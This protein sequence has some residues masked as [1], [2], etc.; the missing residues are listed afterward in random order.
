M[1]DVRE[2]LRLEVARHPDAAGL[3]H[4]REI[5]AAEVDEHHVLGA[6]LLGGEQPLSVSL[7]RLGRTGDRI[8]AR[9]PAFALDEGLG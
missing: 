9:R 7:A 4:S 8:Q 6:V 2:A 3:A 1:R 5:V